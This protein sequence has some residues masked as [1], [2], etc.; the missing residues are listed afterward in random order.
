MAIF[1]VMIVEV[2]YITSH[3][4]QNSSNSTFN[5]GELRFM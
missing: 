1:H 3:V 5:I 4:S 2:V